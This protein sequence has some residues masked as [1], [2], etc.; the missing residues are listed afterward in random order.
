MKVLLTGGTGI[1]GSHV[2]KALL[3]DKQQHEM[4]LLARDPKKV[5][6][7]VGHPRIKF[8]KNDLVKDGV[9]PAWLKG[10]D[11]VIHIALC[12]G[13]KPLDMLDNDTRTTVKLL[14]MSQEAKVKHFIYTSSTAAMGE[15]R[16]NMSEEI[17]TI[18]DNY[19]SATKA[20]SENYLVAMGALSK[21]RCN[22]VRPGYTFADPAVEGAPTEY[23]YDFT[24]KL[25]LKMVQN[26]RENK[27]LKMIKNSGTQYIA[28]DDLAKLYLAVLKSKV[29]RQIYHGLGRKHITQER[30][31]RKAIQLTGS[32]S[33][34]VLDDRGWGVGQTFKV[35][36]MKHDFGLSF[37]SWPKIVKHLKSIIATT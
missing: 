7:F 31:A 2:V 13:D 21:M 26:A 10:Q 3:D 9:K 4:T 28:A 35:N 11:T 34:I 36:K 6:G 23:S 20:S 17:I 29:N 16:E 18:S 19:Y 12:W 22:V 15:I 24:D 14:Q 30:I 8:I 5:K 25:F 1:I 32:K 27:P 37:D 33:K